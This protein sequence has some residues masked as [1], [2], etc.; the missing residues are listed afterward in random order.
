MIELAYVGNKG[1]E[2]CSCTTRISTAARFSVQ[3]APSI[4]TGAVARAPKL[5]GKPLLRR[6]SRVDLSPPPRCQIAN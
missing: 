5:V 3:L 1:N 4:P 6:Y 2:F